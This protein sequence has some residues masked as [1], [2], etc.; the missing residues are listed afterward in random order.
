M[1]LSTGLWKSL[2]GWMSRSIMPGSR[3]TGYPSPNNPKKTTY[4]ASKHGVIGL[5]KSAAL[6]NA[7]SGI[8]VNVACPAVIETPMADRAYGG[9]P[10]VHNFVVGL[11]IGR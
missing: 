10:A 11:P 3:G 9:E 8:R 5:T 4:S 6:E 7:R 1:P 2:A